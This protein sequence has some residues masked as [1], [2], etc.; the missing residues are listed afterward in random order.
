M[1]N[2]HSLKLEAAE[3]RVLQLPLKFKFETSFGVQSE[4]ILPLLTLHSSGLTGVAEGVMDAKEPLYREETVEG[5]LQVVK[6]A[7][8][9]AV[10]GK[11]F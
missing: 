8:L 4:R 6:H 1:S 11:T 3:L 9:P 7:L 10:L 2:P 5:A